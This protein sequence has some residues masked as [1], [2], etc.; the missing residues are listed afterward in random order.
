M[1]RLFVAVWPPDFLIEQL[2][3]LDRPPQPG[4]RWTTE[5]QWHVTLRFLGDMAPAEEEPLSA[6]LG[7]A[8]ARMSSVTAAAGPHPRPLGAVWVLPVAGLDDL[9]RAVGAAT[10]DVGEPLPDRP[11]R[12]HLTL[13]RARRPGL[14][15]GLPGATVA[16]GWPVTDI[17]LVRS[18]L[19]SGGARYEVIGRWPLARG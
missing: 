9:A 18:H 11:Y 13:A 5:D 8:A 12:G 4:L 7:G 6:G 19:G 15:R 2:R 14:L 10:G 16:G 17:T 3:T 1:N